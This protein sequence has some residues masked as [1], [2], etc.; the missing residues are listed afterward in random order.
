MFGGSATQTQKSEPSD[1]IKPYL[2]EGMNEARSLFREG[3]SEF[4]PGS[5]VPTD[6]LGAI[7][8]RGMGGAGGRAGSQY[9]LDQFAGGGLGDW[10]TVDNLRNM[11]TSSIYG[12]S[13][14]SQNLGTMAS[15]GPGT[16]DR[17]L[18]RVGDIALSGGNVAGHSGYKL[19]DIE[20]TGGNVGGFTDSRV[21]DLSTSG[22]NTLA[23]FRSDTGDIIS[24]AA[25]NA[26]PA[27]SSLGLTAGGSFL[28]S[29]PYLDATFDK[30]A[31]KVT[32]AYR[33]AISPAI[34]GRFALSSG[35]GTSGA[36]TQARDQ[37]EENLGTTL[38]DLSTSLYGGEY[39]RER[40]RMLS[41]A[42]TLGGLYQGGL[43]LRTQAA[44]TS[45]GQGTADASTR[46]AA[47]GQVSGD[48]AGDLA[49]RLQAV[50]QVSSD[51]NADQARRLQAGGLLQGAEQSDAAQKIQA[52]QVQQGAYEA[53]ADRRLAAT[54]AA[55]DAY[56]AGRA[57]QLQALGLQPQYQQMDYNDLNAAQTAAQT[58]INADIAKWDYGQNAPW[59]N[60]QRYMSMIA[61][62]SP[63]S[64]SSV[65]STGGSPMAGLLSG[66]GGLGQLA[67]A[68][69]GLV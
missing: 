4:Y 20:R 50:G 30:A 18:G 60:L 25:Q 3:A 59:A 42:G 62:G 64:S 32:R 26:N 57:Q 23:Q 67:L 54:K 47:T 6:V 44:G 52:N 27:Y 40:D 12:G 51:M 5:T 38:S 11:G 28:N 68:L 35:A 15:A 37:A 58:G 29:N 46:L 56:G 17:L 14:V 9:A 43:G 8:A 22:P 53:D 39:G 2:S 16:A 55:N 31:D 19:G 48:M 10:G 7:M 13:P 24:G 65:T 45:A 66:A 61:G 69:R 41:A 34:D 33:T 21:G 36:A 63:G 1:F 49:R